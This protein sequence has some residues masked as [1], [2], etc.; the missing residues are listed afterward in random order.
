M[1]AEHSIDMARDGGMA[2]LVVAVVF[3]TLAVLAVALRIISRR[4]SRVYL[5]ANDYMIIVA[6]VQ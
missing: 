4:L 2:Q 3:G 5:R 6:L 1:A